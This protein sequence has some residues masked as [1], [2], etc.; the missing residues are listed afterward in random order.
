VNGMA[1]T[2]AAITITNALPIGVG[3][4]A[5]IELRA[6]AR[7]LLTEAESGSPS[8]WEIPPESRTPV[9]EEA[10][11]TGLSR[12]FPQ[13]GTVTRL[14]LRSEIP[15]ARGLK[16]SSAVSTSVL[17]AIARAADRTPSPLEIGLLSAEVC[18]RSGVS[19]T[20]ALDDALA[21]LEPGFI[22]T[23]NTHDRLLRHDPIDPSWGV[24]LYIP[25]QRH[26][27]APELLAAFSSGRS[28]AEPAARA[29]R[30]GEWA[31]AMRLN[32]EL[33]ERTLGLHYGS[34]RERLRAEGAVACGVS[35]LGPTLAAIAPKDRLP[36]LLR[37]MPSDSATKLLV[38]FTR[39]SAV[40]GPTP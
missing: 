38:D 37:A 27:P 12:F 8:T 23:D 15:V 20:G 4:A 33:V 32:T 6:E 19:A 21:G 28:S 5:G 14:S 7:V 11:R 35:G 31:A 25:E 30:S 10:V 1:R 9:V 29:A 2:S 22:V 26:A 17:L 39:T 18:R 3:S 16:S 24:A 40:G 36:R 34:L 13:P